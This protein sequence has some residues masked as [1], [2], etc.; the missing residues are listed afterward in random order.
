MIDNRFNVKKLLLSIV[1]YKGFGFPG[2]PVIDMLNKSKID[3][4]DRDYRIYPTAM[5]KK[6]TTSKGYL[7]YT[8]DKLRE[9]VFYYMPISLGGVSL[10]VAVMTSIAGKKKIKMTEIPGSDG[11]VKELISIDDYTISIAAMLS[12][13]DG[14]YPE[15][16][17]SEVMNLYRKNES[18]KLSSA[19]TGTLFDSEDVVITSI[20]FP[21]TEGV[22]NM[23]AIKIECITDVPFELIQD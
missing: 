17:I 7:T 6:M 14:N 18:V 10:P 21:H 13:D 22:E 3:V 4:T 19:L 11:S 12:S 1:G 9:G 5:E 23:Q 20:S 8:S 2:F 16:Q 15:D